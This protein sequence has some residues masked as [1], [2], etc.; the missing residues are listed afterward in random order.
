MLECKLK[1]FTSLQELPSFLTVAE[2][3]FS[4]SGLKTHLISTN[5]SWGT[6]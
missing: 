6:L 2:S 3:M 1:T 5:T 4:Y